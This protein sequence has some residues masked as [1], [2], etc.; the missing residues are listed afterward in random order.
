MQNIAF[1]QYQIADHQPEAPTNLNSKSEW[2]DLIP[3]LTAADNQFLWDNNQSNF[4]LGPLQLDQVPLP[5]PF[6]G[7][8]GADT[9]NLANLDLD[10]LNSQLNSAINNMHDP[11]NYTFQDHIDVQKVLNYDL[12]LPLTSLPGNTS[13]AT[14]ND[15]IPDFNLG[16]PTVNPN[17]LTSHDT[18]YFS[19][20]AP[21]K[22]STQVEANM[23]TNI[24]QPPAAG[25]NERSDTQLLENVST[26]DTQKEA[27]TPTTPHNIIHQSSPP[28][29]SAVVIDLCRME[30]WQRFRREGTEMI[31]STKEKTSAGS[32]TR[33]LANGS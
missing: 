26:S 2:D 5:N 12:L 31:T 8:L 4:D 21:D 27:S 23:S 1:D 7:V 6:I 18:E 24:S 14:I 10:K 16:V 25:S 17:A 32:G 29:S 19:K 15:F 28:D 20:T 9:D 33:L 22:V 3:F 13:S 30:L 11:I